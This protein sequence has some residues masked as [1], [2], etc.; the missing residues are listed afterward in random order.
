MKVLNLCMLGNLHTFLF[1]LKKQ[2]KT[3]TKK[4]LKCLAQGHNTVTP[5]HETQTSNPSISPTLSIYTELHS[6]HNSQFELD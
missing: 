3:T 6:H 2:Q 5:Q 1:D 4:P